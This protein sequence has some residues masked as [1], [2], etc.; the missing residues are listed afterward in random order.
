MHRNRTLRPFE[1]LLLLAGAM[2]WLQ[3]T[4]ACTAAH[5]SAAVVESTPST[6]FVNN[7]D[8]TVTHSKTGLMWKQCAQGLSGSGCATG[9]AA[10]PI[11]SDALKMAVTDTTAGHTDWRLPN[12]KELESL[13]ETCG[14]DPAINQTFFPGTPT[15]QFF[16]SSSSSLVDTT[17]A[18]RVSFNSGRN[19]TDIK[20]TATHYVRL[21]R[22]VGPPDNF[23]AQIL[24]PPPPAA[25]QAGHGSALVSQSTPSTD[26]V[27]NGDG[28]VT[29]SKTGLMWKQCAQGL[30]G[31]GCATGIAA[32]PIWSDALKMAVTDTTAGHTDWRL[33]NKKEL[34]SLVETCGYDPAINQTLFPGT[35]TT[36]FFWSS[37]SSLVDTTQ[38]WRVSF[39]SGRNNTDTKATATHYVRLVR[40]I[41]SPDSFDAQTAIYY[42]VTPSAG[43][44]GTISPTTAQPVAFGATT[45]F[46]I[47]PNAGYTATVGGSCGGTLIGTT[48]TTQ[49]I[50][51]NCTVAAT[52]AT[53]PTYPITTVANPSGSGT[54]SCA[55]NPVTSGSTAICT[56]T[57]T[58]G[59]ALTAIG[60]CGG[61]AG[62]S[63]PYTTGTITAACTVT[64][65][66]TNN[67]VNGACGA[68]QGTSSLFV[69]SMNLCSAGIASSVAT[70]TGQYSWSC[71][72]ANGGTTVS[73]S[74]SWANTPSSGKVSAS[75]SSANCSTQSGSVS[76]AIGQPSNLT[77]P[78]G[79]VNFTLS[80][81]TSGATA[82]LTLQYTHALPTGAQYY[83]NNGTNWAAYPGATI[84]G[85]TVSFS[86]TDNG[87]QDSNPAS[88][89]ITDPSGPAA[90]GTVNPSTVQSAPALSPVGLMLLCG[91]LGMASI[92]MQPRRRLR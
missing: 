84:S 24:P 32:V 41:S 37:S 69:P 72:G 49:P 71:N 9:I 38:A 30:S 1:I 27:N 17:Q 46:T 10:T 89:T 83:K 21:V 28:T 61:T 40:A 20:A 65:T 8:G 79:L 33:P 47:T 56:V 88:G 53:L 64:A 77:F 67:P 19:N 75:A 76:A 52:F 23:D 6:D 29:H 34:E 55:P 11:W 58:T 85:N 13:V 42:T 80:G 81:C 63:S 70:S 74:A 54:V 16:W 90:V 87:M 3:A 45:T 73:C 44:N 43:A 86:I 51:A 59:Y 62:T 50:I 2:S 82:N 35:P 18:W 4:A 15:A 48:Y 92:M 31:S 5:P 26:F 66:F 22:A 25:C 7:G 60:G 68:A 14:Y 36:Q 39:Y 12:K 78:E 91:L 57:A